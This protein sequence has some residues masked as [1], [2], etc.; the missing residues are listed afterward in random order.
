MFSESSHG[1][2]H[3]SQYSIREQVKDI[4]EIKKVLQNHRQ[5]TARKIISTEKIIAFSASHSILK[6]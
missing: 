5:H 6:N 3:E 2:E 1:T 4:A